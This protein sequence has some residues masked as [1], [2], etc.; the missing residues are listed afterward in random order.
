MFQL[1]EIAG[2]MNENGCI[3]VPAVLLAQ[4][5]IRLGEEVK[6]IYLAAGENRYA[7][8]SKEFLLAR[9]DEN[10]LEEFLKEE[11]IELKLPP[12]LLVDANI[13]LDADLDIV[14]M[15]RKIVILPTEDV[16]AEEI[17]KELMDICQELG[18]SKEKVNIILRMSEEEQQDEKA[19]L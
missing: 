11:N 5:G 7:N 2:I 16:E 12:E 13:A 9:A 19:D 18:I 4:T 3:E 8:E 1:V 10:P 15:D 17:P 6:L 14:C